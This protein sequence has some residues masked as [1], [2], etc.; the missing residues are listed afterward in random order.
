MDAKFEFEVYV[1]VEGPADMM[2]CG[3][4]EERDTV[5][6]DGWMIRRGDR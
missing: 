5:V 1:D 3:R 2:D 4:G 6:G